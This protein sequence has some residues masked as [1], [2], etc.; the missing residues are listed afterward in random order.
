[1]V[2][3][4]VGGERRPHVG[5]QQSQVGPGTVARQVLST[6]PSL[7]LRQIILR[8]KIVFVR[9]PLEL[10]KTHRRPSRLAGQG[11]ADPTGRI[12]QSSAAA[13]RRRSRR[14]HH[15]SPALAANADNKER[16]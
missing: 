9:V 8:P 2:N 7:Q 13:A 10:H 1:M 4:L 15:R 14:T 6:Y 11:V 16:L 5:R 3:S 12:T